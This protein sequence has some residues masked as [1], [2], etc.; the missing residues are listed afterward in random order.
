MHGAST[1]TVEPRAK[2][3]LGF[4]DGK[5]GAALTDGRVVLA[6]YTVFPRLARASKSDLEDW[7]P[8]GDGVGINWPKLDEDLSVAGLI[9]DALRID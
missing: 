6:R 7:R 4:V 8:V 2:N 1:G 5:M 3:V 9:R